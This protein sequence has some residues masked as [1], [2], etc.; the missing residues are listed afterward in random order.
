MHTKI[1]VSNETAAQCVL[2]LAKQLH[3]TAVEAKP[4]ESLPILRRVLTTETLRGLTL[5]ELYQKRDMVRRKHILRMLA[6][7]AGRRCWEDYR[8]ALETMSIDQLT[9]FDLVRCQL[10]YPNLWFA[11]RAQ[12]EAHVAKH[13]GCIVNVGTQ[14]VVLGDKAHAV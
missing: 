6:I 12:A 2:R 13:G 14:A 7:E 3:R 4:S 5:P 8:D 11:S 1:V 9:E 10:G